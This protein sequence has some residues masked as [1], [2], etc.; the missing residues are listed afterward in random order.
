MK[1]F[2]DGFSKANNAKKSYKNG[3]EKLNNSSRNAIGQT[4][5]RDEPLCLWELHRVCGIRH[6]LR[7]CRYCP[8]NL[9]KTLFV[10]LA[11]ERVNDG[12]S[13]STRPH[14]LGKLLDYHVTPTVSKI[15]RLQSNSKSFQNSSP[16]CSV[17]INDGLASITAV[18]Q[19]DD[20][21]DDSIASSRV[22][23]EA[24]VKGV[25]RIHST[26]PITVQ[27]VSRNDEATAFF[28]FYRS[29]TAPRITLQLASGK[30]ALT[31]VSFLVA[32]DDL[33]CEELLI[34]LRA[35]RHLRLD[36]KILLEMNRSELDGTD[37]AKVRNPNSEGFGSVGRLMIARNRH[38][39][40]TKY[41]HGIDYIQRSAQPLR[42]R[43]RGHYS[44]ARH[45]TDRY[46]DSS[47]LDLVDE[48]QHSEVM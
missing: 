39:Y 36:S 20:G 5:K 33:S 18:A 30:L 8:E 16:S 6:S 4:R 2:S 15:G 1:D 17:V 12:P 44:D 34:G 26:T 35:P 32:G 40:S 48:A 25:G 10:N 22:A 11:A 37:C 46:P 29:W 13:R 38:V 21:S 31:V 27:V 23:E 9:K 7:D 24:V 43:P 28:R 14:T 41:D 19:C 3:A 42:D 45:D 47:L